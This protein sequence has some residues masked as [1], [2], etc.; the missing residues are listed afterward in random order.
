M[1]E[2]NTDSDNPLKSKGF[3][4]SAVVVGA[5]VVMGAVVS[6]TILVGGDEDPA[7]GQDADQSAEGQI[8]EEEAPEQDIPRSDGSESVCGLKASEKDV[9]EQ[10]PDK[11]RWDRVGLVQAPAIPG[12]GPENISPSG[13]RH[14]YAKSPE[15]AVSAGM[16]YVAMTTDQL[17]MSEVVEEMFAKGPGKEAAQQ[18]L[19]ED[20]G[21]DIQHQ[22]SL[23]GVRLLAYGH[24]RA[25]VD[26]ALGLQ[27]PQVEEMSSF[28]ID[29]RWEEGDWK[30]VTTE[31]GDMIIPMTELQTL[32]GYVLTE[33]EDY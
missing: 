33:A 15:G 29:L 26:V 11:T 9:F 7:P 13:Y 24:D 6:V 30:I 27:D 14:C 32:D 10:W 23:E 12:H 2:E 31:D 28:V 21:G 18:L 5:I 19:A 4:V 16:N 25:R 1:N 20:T 22:G 3:L 8:D 17:A